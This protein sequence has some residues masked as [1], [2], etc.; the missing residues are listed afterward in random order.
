MI[1]DK[2]RFEKLEHH[3][4]GLVKFDNNVGAKIIARGIVKINDGNIRFGEVLFMIGL[5][6]SMLSVSQICDKGHDVIFK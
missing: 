1:R 5:K 2:R 3:E 6:H 4:W